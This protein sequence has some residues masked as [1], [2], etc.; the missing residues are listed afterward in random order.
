MIIGET[1]KPIPHWE[2]SPLSVWDILLAY[3]ASCLTVTSDG[4]SVMDLIKLFE[5]Y[6]KRGRRKDFVLQRELYGGD[7]GARGTLGLFEELMS[8]ERKAVAF[9]TFEGVV[10]VDQWRFQEYDIF[11]VEVFSG[12]H[13]EISRCTAQ[14]HI[15]I[16]QRVAFNLNAIFM[17]P[18]PKRL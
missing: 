2:R 4:Q 6:V 3:G 8:F 18:D 13:F 16:N 11:F 10:C 1:I 5:L 14:A 9:A 7:R 12:T 15:N 17:K